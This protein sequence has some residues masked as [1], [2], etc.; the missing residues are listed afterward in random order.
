MPYGKQQTFM[1]KVVQRID[2]KFPKIISN[3]L[4]TSLV[5]EEF[6][7]SLIK[8]S[9]REYDFKISLVALC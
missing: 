2:G 4:K 6:E 7:S 1:E 8:I 3:P 5:E 9:E